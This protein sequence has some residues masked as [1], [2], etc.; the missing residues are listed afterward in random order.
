MI[1][2]PPRSTRTDTLFPYTTLFR[3][4]EYRS[5]HFDAKAWFHAGTAQILSCRQA[6]PGKDIGDDSGGMGR[7]ENFRHPQLRRRWTYVRSEERRV[8]IESVSTCRS[9]W[10][11]YHLNKETVRTACGRDE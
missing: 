2:R 8:G 1:R 11:S 4:R 10:S 9:R 5:L 3:S 7:C 6:L